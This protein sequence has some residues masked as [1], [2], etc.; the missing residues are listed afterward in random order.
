MLAN[1]VWTNTK[2]LD[3]VKMNVL[4]IQSDLLQVHLIQ[5]RDSQFQISI[6]FSS[7][8]LIKLLAAGGRTAGHCK[9]RCSQTIFRPYGSSN[10]EDTTRKYN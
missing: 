5:Y 1:S 9:T 2:I 3:C 4:F 8:Y 6:Q 7:I 10:N